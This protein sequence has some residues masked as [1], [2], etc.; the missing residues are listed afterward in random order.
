MLLLVVGL[1]H[2]FVFCTRRSHAHTIDR[3]VDH[4]HQHHHP[5]P[6]TGGDRWSYNY[7][8]GVHYCCGVCDGKHLCPSIGGWQLQDCACNSPLQLCGAGAELIR[9]SA[10][11]PSSSWECICGNG[12]V[13]WDRVDGIDA[14]MAERNCRGMHN[15][16]DECC[17]APRYDNKL[18][19]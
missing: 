19:L 3:H 9:S 1:S 12:T 13:V 11:P 17:G 5:H 2:Q 8:G 4:D 6:H 15:R 16:S 18:A 10:W 14:R 7:C